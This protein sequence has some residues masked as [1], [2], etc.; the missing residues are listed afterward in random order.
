MQKTDE[1]SRASL[2]GVCAGCSH[3]QTCGYLGDPAPVPVWLYAALR[4]CSKRHVY[5]LIEE[6]K[7]AH[8]RIL[9]GVMVCLS[10]REDVC[11][12][13]PGGNGRA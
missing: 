12:R 9:G 7:I 3:A 2:R 11:D 4:G 6:R 10:W 5:R 8:G 1:P 13:M